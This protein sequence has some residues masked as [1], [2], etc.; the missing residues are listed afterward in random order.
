MDSS[1]ISSATLSDCPDT[2]AS[3][4]AFPSCDQIKRTL[5]TRTVLST[6]P[7]F[8]PRLFPELVTQQYNNVLRDE[9]LGTPLD[10]LLLEDIYKACKIVHAYS[11]ILRAHQIRCDYD[12]PMA[13]KAYGNM[14]LSA[15]LPELES[16][17]VGFLAGLNRFGLLEKY[18]KNITATLWALAMKQTELPPQLPFLD[19]FPR[20]RFLFP[21]R[22]KIWKRIFSGIAT[23]RD[24]RRF[25]VPFAKYLYMAKAASAEV[26]PSF[27]QDALKKHKEILTTPKE[28][29]ELPDEIY[30]SI[31]ETTDSIFGSKLRKERRPP[32]RAPS[33]GASY[34]ST[35]QNGGAFGE[36]LKSSH[37]EDWSLPAPVEGFLW[38]YAHVSHNPETQEV[39]CLYDPD[40]FYEAE[41]ESEIRAILKSAAGGV[42]AKVVPLVEAFKVR[43][44][45]KG[46]SDM[47]HLARRWQKVI[48]SN[49]R[50]HPQAQLIGQP[51]NEA[52]LSKIFSDSPFFNY[53]NQNGF[54]V[55]GDY[56]SATDLLD[57]R[58]SIEAQDQ[59]SKRLG[60][61]LEHQ[62]VLNKCLTGHLLDY[63]EGTK[64][65]PILHQQQWGQL[66]GSPTSFPVLC[67]VNLAATKLSYEL[68]FQ[69][70]WKS[71]RAPSLKVEELP[72]C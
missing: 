8:A 37:P 11:E 33:M 38:G 24:R 44:I 1:G 45:T 67:L 23:R 47:Y 15:R 6:N 21:T 41:K 36:I 34:S 49:M 70:I 68:Y 58:L 51:C 31:H 2:E 60:I 29:T 65:A 72:M 59:I 7:K 4:R 27:I 53:G 71:E 25:L 32:S 20:F 14:L 17:L 5:Q 54:F 12:L 61:P 19:R 64:E 69:K 22:N 40:L 9:T 56:E 30:R 43:T 10:T 62:I 18:C 57:P 52:F 39:R 16:M 35:R 26:D 46:D 13:Y 50:R 28:F 48:H 55:S 42:P 3:N 63:G 66:M